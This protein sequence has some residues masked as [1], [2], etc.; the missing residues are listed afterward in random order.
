MARK[1]KMDEDDLVRLIDADI[2]AA[3]DFDENELAEPRQRAIDYFEGRMPDTPPA[4]GRSSVVSKDVSEVMGWLMPSLERVFFQTERLGEFEPT[5]PE[6][7]EDAKQATDYLNWLFYKDACGIPALRDAFHDALLCR[8]GFVKVFWSDAKEV[9]EYDYSG[10]TDA[11]FV[12]LVSDPEIEVLEHTEYEDTYSDGQPQAAP[13]PPQGPA[14]GAPGPIPA[15]PVGPDPA[16]PGRLHDAK[17]RRTCDRGGPRVEAV[18]SEEVIVEVGARSVEEARFVAHRA[19]RTREALIADGYDPKVVETLP[20]YGDI[21]IDEE[22][23]ARQGQSSTLAMRSANALR[24]YVEVYECY[25]R[26]DYDGD[27]VEELRRVVIGGERNA[28]SILANDSWDEL[29]LIDF[30]ADPVPHRWYGR[31]IYDDMREI[32]RVKT[33]LMRQILDNIY[34]TNTPLRK[35]DLS[36]VRNPDE[37]MNPTFG[38]FIDTPDPAGIVPEVIPFIAKESFPIIEYMDSLTER[39]TGISRQSMGL[40]PEALQNQTATAAALRQSGAY[41]RVEMYARNL[42][43]S[44]ARVFKSLLRLV[45][46]HQ[47]KSKIIRLRNEFVEVDPRVWNTS[48]D[49]SVNVGLGTGSRERDL[50]MVGSILQFQQTIMQQMGPGNPLVNF[51]Q[52]GNA[53]QKY[54]ESAGIRNPEMFFSQPP[55]GWQP[56]PPPPP[57]QLQIEQ[58]KLQAQQMKAQAEMQMDAQKAQMQAQQAQA[59]AQLKAEMAREEAAAKLQLMR[60]EAAAKIATDRELGQAKLQIEAQLRRQ[61]MEIEAQL[62]RESMMVG[63][64]MQAANIQRP[65]M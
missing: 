49:V 48:M 31:S 9:T 39:R 22:A 11:Q 38:G 4:D 60:E 18:P 10:L 40:D 64:Q 32:Q 7:V 45:T 65:E 25:V 13:V 28:R 5:K 55:P 42:S 1:R 29:T 46:K 63:A 35:G 12:K 61:E 19:Y 51:E 53:L 47:D 14:P 44:V 58:Q 3:K 2:I 62:K 33:V 20:A 57:P 59:E 15:G 41:A 17:V 27:G 54:A 56:P 21:D 52:V 34:A 24:E 37:L 8:V 26:C 36:K 50:A 23:Q 6:D 16:G 30:Q 43:W